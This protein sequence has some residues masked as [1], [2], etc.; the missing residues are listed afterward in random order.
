[1]AEAVL[2]RVS[3]FGRHNRGPT[4]HLGENVYEDVLTIHLVVSTVMF[5]LRRPLLAG[6]WHDYRLGQPPLATPPLENTSA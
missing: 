2:R 1:M 3:W 6:L 4:T 5:S